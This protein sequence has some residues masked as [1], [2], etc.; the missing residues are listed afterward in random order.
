[1]VYLL[2]TGT[3]RADLPLV[4]TAHH[5]KATAA[6]LEVVGTAPHHRG[7]EL[8]QEDT[9]EGLARGRIRIDRD[10]GQDLDPR[11]REAG[12]GILDPEVGRR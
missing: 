10:Q 5:H 3:K 8:H 7:V 2:W 11:D 4:P 12:A 9:E 1:M 6:H